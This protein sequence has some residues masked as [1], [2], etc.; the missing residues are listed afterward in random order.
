MGALT[1]GCCGSVAVQS[2][3]AAAHG[4]CSSAEGA[5]LALACLLGSCSC[6]LN[7]PL[8]AFVMLHVCRCLVLSY[9]RPS[10]WA[11]EAAGHYMWVRPREALL[12]FWWR[13]G[14]RSARWSELTA[15]AAHRST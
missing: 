10:A 6:V 11:C 7:K 8:M 13:C 14:V 2:P 12:F 15:P 3:P 9:V 4:G 5:L 1:R